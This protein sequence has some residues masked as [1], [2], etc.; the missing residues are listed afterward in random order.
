MRHT[1]YN[2]IHASEVH[3]S[4]ERRLLRAILLDSLRTL[5]ATT[6]PN[7]SVRQQKELTWITSGDRTE[8]FAFE[9]VCDALGIDA[10]YLRGRVMV[11]LRERQAGAEARGRD[12]GRVRAAHGAA[13]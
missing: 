10:N 1:P 3:G 5:L 4:G 6:A 13:A 9:H 12:A 11:A 8:V 7:R 2:G